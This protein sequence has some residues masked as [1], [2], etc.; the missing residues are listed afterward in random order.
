M[1]QLFIAPGPSS[2]VTSPA[3]A[4]AMTTS[5]TSGT[6]KL[7]MDFFIL[8]LLIMTHD[9]SLL[10]NYHSPSTK[11]TIHTADDTS[12]PVTTIRSISNKSLSLTPVLCVPHLSINLISVSQLAS[13]G[14]LVSFSST[15]WSLQDSCTGRQIGICLRSGDLYYLCSLHLPHR[16]TPAVTLVS[17]ATLLPLWH[18]H[19]GHLSL[20]KMKL[21]VSSGCLGNISI[22]DISDCFGCRFG[23]Q[24]A[25]PYNKNLYV[26]RVPFDLVH[27]DTWGTCISANKRG[28][29]LLC[30]IY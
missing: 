23:K 29:F 1:Q 7:C 5:D 9:L 4:S 11:L 25:L 19:L 20:N 16:C 28:F 12:L 21:L 10:H 27:S 6:K 26:T 15:G 30:A 14:Y 8:E 3:S 13:S 24:H 2:S 17:S 22:T 18:S